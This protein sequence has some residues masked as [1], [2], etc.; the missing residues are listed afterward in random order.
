[1]DQQERRDTYP[2]DSR[3]PQRRA[4]NIVAS[5][6][7]ATSESM[8]PGDSGDSGERTQGANRFAD[9]GSP[10][11]H[12]GEGAP[13]AKANG[14]GR[15]LDTEIAAYQKQAA[16]LEAAHPGKWA[17]F[18]GKSLVAIHE[19]FDAAAAGAVNQFGRGPF[20]I[21]QTPTLLVKKLNSRD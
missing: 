17:V 15:P 11:P 21:R 10:D 4:K 6:C 20:L 18:K 3:N 16:Q 2:R 13:M 9:V 12:G 14:G 8:N 7:S 1:M 19:T 5:D